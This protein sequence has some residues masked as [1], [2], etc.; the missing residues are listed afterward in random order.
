[1]VIFHS[2]VK[3]PEGIISGGWV[4]V[5]VETHHVLHCLLKISLSDLLPFLEIGPKLSYKQSKFWKR[6]KLLQNRGKKQKKQKTKSFTRP[7][8]SFSDPLYG[9][10]LFFFV[11]SRFWTLCQSNNVSCSFFCFCFPFPWV[12]GIN[13]HPDK[14]PLA[15]LSPLHFLYWCLHWV[16]DFGYW[17][18]RENVQ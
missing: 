6:K 2:Y 11:F 5:S 12:P 10:K 13:F 4:V 18:I 14:H 15:Q 3:L 9:S 1:M 8:S 16:S 17:A 7:L